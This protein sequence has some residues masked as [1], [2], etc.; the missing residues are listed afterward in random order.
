MADF[1]VYSPRQGA[2]AMEIQRYL[3][4]LCKKR[5][6]DYSILLALIEIES[7]FSSSARS[8]QNAQGYMQIIPK[9]HK[10]LMRKLGVTDLYDA[11]G[12]LEVGTAILA[13]HLEDYGGDYLKALTAYNLGGG[14]AAKIFAKGKQ[15]NQYAYHIVARAA[16]IR[17]ELNAT[18]NSGR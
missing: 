14:G 7:G 10:P 11:K 5:G 4:S 8:A 2:M 12:N 9:W 3:Y 1:R 13:A 15:G 18:K 17:R 6:L 16:Q